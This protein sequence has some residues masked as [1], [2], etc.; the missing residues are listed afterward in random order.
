MDDFKV[1]TKCRMEKNLN[2]FHK[3]KSNKSGYYTICKTCKKTKMKELRQKY[4]ILETREIKDK[5]VCCRCKKEKNIL[6]FVKNRCCKDGFDKECK[7]CKYKYNHSYSE[8]RKQYD[9]EFKILKN[10]RSRL[11]ESLRGKSK[12]Q[13]TCQLIGVDFE[14]FTK[15]IEFQLEE[16]MTM[17]NY[18]SVWHLDHVLPLSSFNLLDEEELLKAMNWKNIR[19]LLALKNIQK[20]NKIDRWLYVV[21]EVK[22]NYFLK[23]LD[24]I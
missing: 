9:P 20:S 24:E 12:S 13:T 19:P 23:H 5:K 7:E 3:D 15:W 1:C 8:A 17:E 11:S 16:G 10:M 21:Q 18:G 22:S 14:I 4:S 6:E 2:E